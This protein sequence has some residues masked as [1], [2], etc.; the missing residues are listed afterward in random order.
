MSYI[1]KYGLCFR[2]VEVD[3]AFFILSLRTN[4]KLN[5]HLSPTKDNLELQKKW[6]KKYKER[7]ADEKE[8]Y[9]V[10]EDETKSGY[11]LTRIYNTDKNSFEIGSWVFA[12]NSPEGMPIKADILCKEIGFERLNFDYCRF[13]VRKK[14]KRVNQYYRLF[15]PTLV[16]EDNDNN[17]YVLTKESFYNKKEKLLHLIQYG[18]FN[19]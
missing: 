3:D 5:K 15:N 9:F 13:E 18:K 14:N 7:E 19:G 2:F 8:F 11:G 17:Y 1:K 12:E 16:R 10:C 6:I 4:P